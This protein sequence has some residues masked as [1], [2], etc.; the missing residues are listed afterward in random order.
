MCEH[1]NSNEDLRDVKGFDKIYKELGEKPY[2]DLT[3][4]KFGRL[5]A[6]RAVGRKKDGRVLWL[7]ECECSNEFIADASS[8]K[9]NKC[10]SCGCLSIIKN[11]EKR[12]NLEGKIFT[13]W[14]VIKDE[15]GDKVLCRCSCGTER[16]VDRGNLRGKITTS[17]G[18]LRKEVLHEAYKKDLTG[19]VFGRLT[20][21]GL[22]GRDDKNKKLLW[23][24][25]CSCGTEKIVSGNLLTV[26]GIRSC[27]CLKREQTIER[28]TKP[29]IGKVF[30]R[31]TV[32]EKAYTKKGKGAYYKCLCSC[33]E[34]VIVQGS[35]LRSGNSRSCGCINKERRQQ[36]EDLSGRRF[37]KL[38]VLK[39]VPNKGKGHDTRYLC[40]CDCGGLT[41]TARYS[42]LCGETMSCGCINSKGEYRISQILNENNMVFERQKT[43]EDFRIGRHGI[44]KFDFYIPEGNYIIEYDGQQHFM[45]TNLGWNDKE[46][47][48]KV[49]ER[50][51][52]KNEYCK[53]N[54]IPIIRIPYTQYNDLCLDDLLLETSQFVLKQ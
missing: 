10:R 23:K 37:G 33:G 31:L 32:L 51:R 34:T 44:P 4:R 46:H 13:R 24:V 8:L 6:A 2:E 30:G 42:L 52:L 27:G 9:G 19:K 48:E 25:R 12:E 43:Y 11:K 49:Q 17:C 38:V 14:T 21:L 53:K 35:M 54:N 3:G 20:V 15:G 36:Y 50:D 29:M 45:H 22:A 1:C 47:F 16:W 5:T 28:C 26:K 41:E 40:K 18:C 7:C 39:R